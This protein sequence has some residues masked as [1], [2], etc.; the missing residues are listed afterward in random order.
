MRMS[1]IDKHKLIEKI[2]DDIECAKGTEAI[3]VYFLDGWIVRFE[4]QGNTEQAETLRHVIDNWRSH[5]G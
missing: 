4:K 2:V 3:P 5:N 1:A